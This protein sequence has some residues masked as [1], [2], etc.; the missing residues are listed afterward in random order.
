MTTITF[1]GTAG[2]NAAVTK[3]ARG[4]GGI[5]IQY[6]ELQFHLDPGPGSITKCKEYGINPHNTTAILVS[7]NNIIH[8]NDINII[9]DAMTHG[10]IERHGLIMGSKTVL[11]GTETGYPFITKFYQNL[12]DKVIPF[13]KNHRI[14]IDAV[15]ISA[16]PLQNPDPNSTGFKFHFPNFTIGYVGDTAFTSELSESL[17]GCDLLIINC[18]FP[19]D[20]AQGPSLDRDR[21]T[22][23]V[24]QVRPKLVVLTHFSI[25]M[26]KAD[27][28][29][30][31]RLIQSATGVQT[32]AATDGLKIAPEGFRSYKAP[33]KGF[34]NDVPRPVV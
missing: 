20:K 21:A 3:Q 23:L 30:E 1:L 26:L 13:E 15:E 6:E 32:I 4:S 25:D 33:I 10:G 2:T 5:V 34:G 16:V 18:P 8:C 28:L 17:Q 7:D 9:I 11:Q 22:K 29:Q 19:A 14:G 12:V 27:P 31:A 24:A